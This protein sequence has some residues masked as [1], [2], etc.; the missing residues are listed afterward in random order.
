VWEVSLNSKSK[1]AI[2][3]LSSVLVV[4]VIVGGMLGRV[5]AQDG[6]YQQLSIFI[7]V[8]E[9]I[10]SD[11]V[12]EPSLRTAVQGAIR[13]MVEMVDPY[14][15][16]LMPQEVAFYKDFDLEK[17]PGIGVILSRRAGYPVIISSIPGGPAARAGLT[18]G[19]YIEAI[20]GVTTR[21]MNLVQ[22]NAL[23]A[24]PVGKP[25]SIVAIRRNRAEPETLE[26][27]RETVKVPPVVSRMLE[28]NVAYIQLPL[29][30]RGKAEET[31]KHLDDLLRKGASGVILDLRFTAGS[32]EDESIDLANLFVD[33]GTIGFLEGQKV[34][35][36]T[37][38]ANPGDAITKMPLVVLVNQGTAGG[39]E[40][41]AAAVAEN[42]RGQVV[43]ARTFGAASVQELIPLDGG[44]ALLLSVAKYFTPSGKE[45]QQSGIEPTLEVGQPNEDVVDPNS[46]DQ[47]KAP[48][49]DPSANDEDRQLNKALEILRNP[50]ASKTAA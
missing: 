33:S 26:L 40:L 13:G 10:K 5:S 29:I 11:Y 2:L 12:D 27:A 32:V 20:D 17:T 39:A 24:A 49:T 6:S 19:D 23:L 46:E 3:L 47:L 48:A 36:K 41:V 9:R 28:N 34:A 25:V 30:A 44:S 31:R 37:F 50:Q 45:I 38:T 7:E 1:Y 42:K 4:Y 21:E 35:R 22:V 14:G 43:G 18:T 8:L 15:G 16:L